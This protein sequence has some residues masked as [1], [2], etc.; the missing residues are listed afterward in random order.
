MRCKKCG[1]GCGS[2]DEFGVR[3]RIWIYTCIGSIVLYI[4]IRL[5]MPCC[6]VH[7]GYLGMCACFACLLLQVWLR[8]RFRFLFRFLL[9]KCDFSLYSTCSCIPIKRFHGIYQDCQCSQGSSSRFKSLPPS[10]YIDPSL[11]KPPIVQ[12]LC[13]SSFPYWLRRWLWLLISYWVLIY[14]RVV[15]LQ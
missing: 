8:F 6:R 12:L 14:L 1:C 7:N 9:E 10:F 13:P 5:L 3:I 4:F 11:Q 15:L 2:S